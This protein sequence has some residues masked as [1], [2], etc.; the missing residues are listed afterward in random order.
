M[1]IHTMQV[2][3][4]GHPARLV[5]AIQSLSLDALLLRSDSA[6]IIR[7]VR[8][9]L[10]RAIVSQVYHLGGFTQVY[11]SRITVVNLAKLLTRENGER[12]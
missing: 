6:S 3:R 10:E 5:E 4:L 12:R 9:D 8:V 1:Y 2:V 7:D 11:L